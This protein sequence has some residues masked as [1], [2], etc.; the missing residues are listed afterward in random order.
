MNNIFFID[1]NVL[2]YEDLLDYINFD[3]SNIILSDVE[4]FVFNEIKRLSG[5]SVENID[6]LINKIKSNNLSLELNTSGTT[7]KPKVII[8]TVESITKNIKVGLKHSNLI[9]GLTYY[10]GKMAFYQV[11]F[12]S[13]F[14]QSTLVNLYGYTFDVVGDRINKFEVNHISAT[15]TFYRMLSSSNEKYNKITQVTLGGESSTEHIILLLKD[16][17]P[18]AKIKNIYASTE[19]ASLFI[20][21]GF[22]FKISEKYK[23][24]IQIIEDV[25]HVHTDLLGE[26]NDD[27]VKNDWYNTQ[28]IVEFINENEFKFIGRKNSEI[29]ISGFKVNPIK[30]ESVLY[31]LPYVLNCRVFSK[32]NSVTGNILCCDVVLKHNV[33][34]NIIKE[35]LKIVLDR[36]E[37]PSIINFVDNIEINE[38]VKIIRS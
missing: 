10:Q 9:W 18:N 37:V 3:T 22:N 6:D 27:N 21:D 36:V 19:T 7:G 1:K 15:P 29:N 11:I 25:L 30:I 38:N 24:K 23:N 13:L 4:I 34:K 17:F 31:T 32:K 2:T 28:D 20:S 16:I 8:H 33:K 14:N 26:I 35:D 12:Q 5:G